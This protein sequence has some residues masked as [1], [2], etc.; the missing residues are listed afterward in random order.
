[1]PFANTQIAYDY[2]QSGS[3]SQVE[4]FAIDEPLLNLG[5]VHTNCA[6]PLL[7]KGKAI[8]LVQ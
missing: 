6:I 1:M 8:E 2:F 4:L 3:A 5:D 7:I